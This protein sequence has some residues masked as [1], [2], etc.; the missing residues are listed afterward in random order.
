V[1][2]DNSVIAKLYYDQ[3]KQG[4]ANH[5]KDSQ[6]WCI[7]GLSDNPF[8]AFANPVYNI[9]GLLDHLNQNKYKKVGYIPSFNT[10]LQNM[11]N[12]TSQDFKITGAL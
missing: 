11:V 7:M 3:R 10:L 5:N 12:D 2:G 6:I 1:L 4:Y 8:L 9:Y